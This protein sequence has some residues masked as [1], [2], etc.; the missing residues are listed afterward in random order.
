MCDN[1]E[2]DVATENKLMTAWCYDLWCII[3]HYKDL[4]KNKLLYFDYDVKTTVYNYQ[5]L[6][7]FTFQVGISLYL[8][9]TNITVD[10]SIERVVP[11]CAEESVLLHLRVDPML[12]YL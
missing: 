5:N 1:W 2:T 6:L 11:I 7:N 3:S 9:D 8:N 4:G 10:T 12:S